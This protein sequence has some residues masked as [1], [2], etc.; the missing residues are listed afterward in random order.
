MTDGAGLINRSALRSLVNMFEWNHWPTATQVRV[1]GSKVDA[2]RFVFCY[3]WFSDYFLCRQGLLV[4]DPDDSSDEPTI[5]LRPSQVK[6][7]YDPSLPIDPARLTIDVLTTS[8]AGQH[9]F[10]STQTIMNLFS[11]DVPAFAFLQLL[12]KGLDDLRTVLMDWEGLD[13]MTRLWCAVYRIG[14]VMSKR[15]AREDPALARVKGHAPQWKTDTVDDDDD[16]EQE[17]DKQEAQSAIDEHSGTPLSLEE[18]I[19]H[20]LD[21][22]MTP[23]NCIFLRTKLESF[24]K[25]CINNYILKFRIPVP[26]SRTALMVPGTSSPFCILASLL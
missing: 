14:R 9:C 26:L 10:L 6:I 22:G 19:L 21:A 15:G 11:N 8:H 25:L 12:E 2:F 23:Q 20:L 18:T 4:L 24:V 17:I 7:Q 3:F 16:D 1:N 13:A 5:R